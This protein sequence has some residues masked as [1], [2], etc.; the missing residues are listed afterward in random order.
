MEIPVDRTA[1]PRAPP[2]SEA[3]GS[4][5]LLNGDGGGELRPVP[6]LQ[7]V[8]LQSLSCNAESVFLAFEAP[9]AKQLRAELRRR[10]PSL[11]GSGREGD[12]SE[13]L[14]AD[15]L[16]SAENPLSSWEEGGVRRGVSVL[17]QRTEERKAL[18]WTGFPRAVSSVCEFLR[19]PQLLAQRREQLQKLG[20]SHDASDTANQNAEGGR[21][22]SGPASLVLATEAGLLLSPLLA[23]DD[24]STETSLRGRSK[25]LQVGAASDTVVSGLAGGSSAFFFCL[26]QKGKVSTEEALL[27]FCGFS[28]EGQAAAREPRTT[29]FSLKPVQ[30]PLPPCRILEVACSSSHVLAVARDGR[31]FAWGCNDGGQLGIGRDA[32]R[33]GAVS[34]PALVALGAERVA[35]VAAGEKF[36]LAASREEDGG[37]LWSWGFNFCGQLGLGH[38]RTVW[39]PERVERCCVLP[40]VSQ[41]VASSSLPPIRC[42][43]AGGLFAALL[44]NDGLLLVQGRLPGEPPPRRAG[45]TPAAVLSRNFLLPSISPHAMP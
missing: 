3:L 10:L 26:A 28:F 13:S 24:S 40:G 19:P 16:Q 14:V 25:L 27:Y 8:V 44:T 35:R 32:A 18:Q 15:S 37:K 21:R 17:R 22:P 45:E 39:T 34:A 31:C 5:F 1:A 30:Q 6:E 42:V 11:V 23:N 4:A 20:S 43:A 38:T 29:F 41:E 12:A 36:S 2:A 7:G 33:E 9:T